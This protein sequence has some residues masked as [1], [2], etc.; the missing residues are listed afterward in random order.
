MSDVLESEEREHASPVRRAE[1][2]PYLRFL[3][4]MHEHLKPDWYLEIGTNTG[5]SLMRAPGKAIAVDPEFII[6]WNVI[7]EKP[8]LHMFRQT[9]DDFFASGVAAK[10]AP[11]ID[12]AFLDGLHLFEFL[13]RDFMNTEKLCG[14]DSV[15]AMHDV[16]PMTYL[17][18][19]REWDRSRTVNWTGD[20]WKLVPVL[21]KYRPDLEIAVADC[22]PSG[23]LLVTR[24]DPE[25]DVLTEA[26]D[27][28]MAEWRDLS[29]DAFGAA[30]LE[31][32]LD[33]TSARDPQMARFI[34]G[35]PAAAPAVRSKTRFALRLQAPDAQKAPR[36][37][38]FNLAKGLAA[39]FNR[40]GYEAEIQPVD[41]WGDAA[42][43]GQVDL[44]LWGQR[45]DYE[46]PVGR[47]TALWLLYNAGAMDTNALQKIR[48]VFVASAP[49]TKKLQRMF[50][51][52]HVSLLL[53]AF[54]ADLM[55]P[56]GETTSSGALFI[57]NGLRK[58]VRRTVQL[59]LE[60]GVEIDL[61]GLRWAGT[62]AER[63]LKSDY[64]ENEDL[65]RYYR[66]AGAVLNDHRFVMGHQGFVSNRI[67]DGLACGAP[68]VSDMVAGLPEDV[69]PWLHCYD[70][71]AEF[72]ACVAAAF[73][74][75]E[76]RRAERHEFARDLAGC[77]SLDA[78][79]DEFIRMLA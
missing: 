20:V 48:H 31:R 64:I 36:W 14:P 70:A 72:P 61:Y 45:R 8:Q 74:E 78:R 58:R 6:R 42:M 35:P 38:E 69:E 2:M 22:A 52:D 30:K 29:I 13:L 41:R 57:A 49:Q 54:D 53:Q 11:K 17:A 65:A 3:R 56:D 27:E 7:A 5:K 12:F 10:L 44:L 28:I 1:G 4:R 21:R 9:S 71:D 75:T 77:H 50:G 60:Y 59:A 67:F 51:A 23:L 32:A 63:F 18:A 16:V 33:T 15:I 26:Y 19:E 47:P 55:S 25:N 46:M 73:D 66:G 43:P 68:V 79:A 40:R 62:E 76:D 34:G 37:G 39:A 24:L